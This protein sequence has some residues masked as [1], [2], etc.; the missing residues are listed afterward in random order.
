[1]FIE[2][3]DKL[4]DGAKRLLELCGGSVQSRSGS[5][6]ERL[7]IAEAITQEPELASSLDEYV[8]YRDEESAAI[9]SKNELPR[10]GHSLARLLKPN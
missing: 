4:S 9:C 6:D 2:E 10:F 7:S 1:M 8:R 5:E 3:K